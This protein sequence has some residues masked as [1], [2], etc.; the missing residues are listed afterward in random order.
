MSNHAKNSNQSCSFYV[1][2]LECDFWW[3]QKRESGFFYTKLALKI[4]NLI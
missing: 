2:V 3:L 1:K 4:V